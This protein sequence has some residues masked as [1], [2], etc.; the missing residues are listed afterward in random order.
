MV[1]QL[2]YTCTNESTITQKTNE[3]TDSVGVTE[4]QVIEIHIF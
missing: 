4:I 1:T 2:P 3:P